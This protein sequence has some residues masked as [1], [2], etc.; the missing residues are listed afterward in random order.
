[1]LCPASCSVLANRNRLPECHHST[2]DVGQVNVSGVGQIGATTILLSGKHEDLSIKNLMTTS[3]WL[4][5]KCKDAKR[6]V[7][8][9]SFLRN[10]LFY[11]MCRIWGFYSGK[12]HFILNNLKYTVFLT[13]TGFTSL[14]C[15]DNCT[16]KLPILP[17]TETPWS[18]L[19][20]KKGIKRQCSRHIYSM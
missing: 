10:F 7:K 1:M 19:G 6:F 11:C 3:W 5:W 4:I 16:S 12:F 9:K 14:S 15:I 13:V 2:R 17:H 8:H 18:L 20:I